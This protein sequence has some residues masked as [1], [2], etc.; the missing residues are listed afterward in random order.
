MDR[1]KPGVQKVK[2]AGLR[3]VN[4]ARDELMK[5]AL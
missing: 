1:S 2:E 4:A 3:G 5:R